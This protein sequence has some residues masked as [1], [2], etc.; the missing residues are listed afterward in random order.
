MGTARERTTSPAEAFF[1]RLGFPLPRDIVNRDIESAM[2]RFARENEGRLP[3]QVPAEALNQPQVQNLTGLADVLRVFPG[4]G[5]LPE[6]PDP[7]APPP[8]RTDPQTA[9]QIAELDRI[10]KVRGLQQGEV[11]PPS[12]FLPPRGAPGA[13]GDPA[14]AFRLLGE[15][16]GQRANFEAAQASLRGQQAMLA[17]RE[18][19]E[20]TDFSNVR[21]LLEES[22]IEAP[23]ERGLKDFLLNALVGAGTGALSQ[24]GRRGRLGQIDTGSVAGGAATGALQGILGVREA[25][26][27]DSLRFQEQDRRAR[28]FEASLLTRI[29][30]I[31]GQESR[32]L[33]AQ[34]FRTSMAQAQIGHQILKAQQ[35]RFSIS[36]NNV[37]TMSPQ[38]VLHSGP[39]DEELAKATLIYKRMQSRALQ[40]PGG[41]FTVAGQSLSVAKGDVD[42]FHTAVMA[43]A[44]DSEDLAV[45]IRRAD[46]N[47]IREIMRVEAQ[48]RVITDPDELQALHD[49]AAGIYAA[50][51]KTDPD[52]VAERRLKG[53]MGSIY[54]M[55]RAGTITSEDMIDSPLRL[56]EKDISELTE[57]G[58]TLSQEDI[59]RAFPVQG[60][61]R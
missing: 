54:D 14:S 29:G 27:A 58:Q 28:Q 8:G 3:P 25:N 47:E 30:S 6:P 53:V 31:E 59:V 55:R 24:A 32:L 2:T 36:G 37:V 39:I 13:G 51:L 12:P 20:P 61:G 49:T 23:P 9:A 35:V 15:I 26:R 45:T 1:A 40:A 5:Q 4:I 44:M 52:G 60:T 43:Q 18:F 10:F 7:N 19:P 33:E 11:G 16:P 34:K 46:E 21:R 57:F 50:Q 22:R 48:G 38:G 42:A 41:T 56:I 17:S